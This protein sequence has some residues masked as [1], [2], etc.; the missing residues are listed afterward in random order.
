MKNRASLVLMEQ[1]IMLLV[2]AL[3]ASVCLR[4]FIRADQIARE[5][6]LRDQ[7]VVLAQNGA[8]TLKACDGNLEKAA[9]ILGGEAGRNGLTVHSD[10]LRLEIELTPSG[11]LGL[12]TAQV[13]VVRIETGKLLFSLTVGWQEV[14]E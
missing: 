2:F 12:G 5:T 13:R 11:I 9:H 4:A 6:A 10:E 8:E 7:A 14:R 3:T 1:L